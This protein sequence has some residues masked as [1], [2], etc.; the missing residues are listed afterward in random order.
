[1]LDNDNL[2]KFLSA[3]LPKNS[4]LLQHIAVSDKQA[5]SAICV[6]AQWVAGLAFNWFRSFR[7][8]CKVIPLCKFKSATE[9]DISCRE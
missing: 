9:I 5:F 4:D 1:M 7:E 8:G 3:P 6:T 2:L